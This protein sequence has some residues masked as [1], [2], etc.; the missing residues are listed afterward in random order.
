MSGNKAFVFA[1]GDGGY[2]GDFRGGPEPLPV[3]QVFIDE[4]TFIDEEGSTEPNEGID[5]GSGDAEEGFVSGFAA[6]TIEEPPP[7]EGDI[8]PAPPEEE[9]PLP[10]Q[11]LPR[12]PNG[13]GGPSTRVFE[14]DLSNP[15]NL[16]ITNTLSIKG[17]YIS[18]RSIGDT[19]RVVVTS[20]PQELGFLYPSGPNTE[21]KAEEANQDIVRSSTVED[22]VPTYDLT[23]SNGNVSSG[24][25]V[26]CSGIHAPADFGGFDMLSIVSLDLGGGLAA[27]TNTSSVM[28]TGDTVYAS[29]DRM[30]V[31]TNLWNPVIDEQTGAWLDENYET[32][33]HRFSIAGPGPATY[34]ASGSIDGHLLNQFSM[35]D[36][37]GVFYAATT[38]GAPWNS[39]SSESQIVALEMNG[40]R[41]EQV[42]AVGGLGLGERIFSVRY[43][44]DT[45]YVVTFRQTDPFYV[46]DIGDP[47]AMSVQGELKIP[48]FSSYLHPIG[49]GLVLGVGQDATD[50]G[51]T[52]GTK[53]S[54]FNV[55]DPSNPTEVD[56]WTLPDGFSDAEFDHRAFLYWAETG[57]AVLPLQS[58]SDQFAGAVVLHVDANGI[59]EQGRISHTDDAGAS[60][61]TDCRVLTAD[62][63]G[64][65]E[66]SE[67]FWIT[68]GGG[69]VQLCGAN[70]QGG[71]TG[72]YCDTIPV[73]ELQYYVD[74]DANGGFDIDLTDVDHLE[75]CWADWNGYQVAVQRTM[76]IDGSLWTLSPE[77]LQAN[78]LN[79]LDRTA[80]I[81]L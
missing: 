19:A 27:P 22:W 23:D 30:Y 62:D 78:D 80:A 32:A 48:G 77:R 76:V 46:I 3:D 5:I 24:Q 14:I 65:E 6:P 59:T 15:D 67:L 57:T 4:P 8:E 44:D 79:T 53:V 9:P 56:V 68:E 13:Y 69:Q 50:D 74:S 41:L 2:Y 25:L 54:L 61:Q 64:P 47:R 58:W 35:N 51:R 40:D 45:A 18:A 75:F 43:V 42:G 66:G 71:A 34:E 38:K 21:D 29:Q 12:E 73:E 63:L 28:A 16:T 39:E 52:T 49:D 37:D 72:M 20:P 70:D 36:R 17:R 7:E 10:D 31:S 60:G 1:H 11:P 26:E 33:I 81:N 55:S